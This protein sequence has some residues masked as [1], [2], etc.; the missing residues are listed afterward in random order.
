MSLYEVG[1]LCLKIAGRDAG[2]KCVIIENV[3][4]TFV[5]VDGATRRKKVNIKHLEPLAVTVEIKEKASHEDVKSAFEKLEIEVWDKKSK[6]V[7]DRPSK[8]RKAAT[9]TKPVKSKK[10]VNQKEES[11]VKE[12]KTEEPKTE[13]KE[14]PKAEPSIEDTVKEVSVEEKKEEEVSEAKVEVKEKTEEQKE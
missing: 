12:L 2:K 9:K 14:Q 8:V 13:P 5:F 10:K 4:D 7:A 11:V 6:K 1:R 3:D